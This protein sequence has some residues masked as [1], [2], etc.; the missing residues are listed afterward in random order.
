MLCQLVKKTT[1]QNKN[2]CCYNFM[3]PSS[4]RDERLVQTEQISRELLSTASSKMKPI[5]MKANHWNL[6]QFCSSQQTNLHTGT[7]IFIF[8]PCS[9]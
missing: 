1:Q 3:W 7:F 5:E 2:S 8:A 6:L 9:C 4:E